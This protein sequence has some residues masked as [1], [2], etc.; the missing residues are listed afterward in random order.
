MKKELLKISIIF[1]VTV[2]AVVWALNYIYFGQAPKSKAAGETVS[3]SF[4]PST[5]SGTTGPLTTTIKA[6][7]SAAITLRGYKF[8][9]N[10]D[11][12]NVQITDINYKIGTVSLDLGDSNSTLSSV[13]TKGVIAV[14]GEIY[15]TGQPLTKSLTDVV[16]ITFTSTTASSTVTITEGS[17]YIIGTDFSI[18]PASAS[19]SN[20]LS[21]NGG[22]SPTNIPVPTVTTPPGQPT[23]T[24]IP[25]TVTPGGPTLT[26]TML[27]YITNWVTPYASVRFNT[28]TITVN[29]RSFVVG[30]STTATL[31]SNPGSGNNLTLEATWFDQGTEMRFYIYFE[32]ITD[33]S[34]SSF[35]MYRISEIRTYDGNTPGDWIY[36]YNYFP[37][38]YPLDLN[39]YWSDSQTIT[40]S[41]ANSYGNKTGQIS[42]GNYRI[43]AFFNQ[44]SPTP[45]PIV[46]LDLKLK[47]QG[48]LKMPKTELNKLVVKVTV[49]NDNLN[50]S[51]TGDFVTTDG[52]TWHDG[53]IPFDIPATTRYTILIKGPYHLQK[54]ICDTVPTETAGGTYRCTKGNITLKNGVNDL[55]LSGIILLAGDLPDQDGTV[56]SYDTSLIRNNLG[57][58]DSTS[59]AN[60]DVNR[61]GVVDTQD[62]SLVIAALS[63]KNDEE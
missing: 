8:K 44:L 22:T 11:K 28:L 56:S 20:S 50:Q 43:Q 13:N 63:V 18:S 27:P 61:D 37:L 53:A 4:S 7:P 38:T 29:R 1:F 48:I 26:P 47:F 25:P 35:P 45:T 40:F 52:I 34:L 46:N 30:P 12:S 55:D 60:S 33:S 62:Y 31:N 3:L 49:K 54:K 5:V 6:L 2:F 59:V 57:K 15:S 32:K 10:F 9:V 19:A 39:S 51:A 23:N 58:I 41:G 24:P 16:I 42:I 17:F 21:V 36:Y 14:Q